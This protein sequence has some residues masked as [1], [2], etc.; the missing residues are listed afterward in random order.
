[1]LACEETWSDGKSHTMLLPVEIVGKRAEALSA[2]EPG[3]VVCI[4]GKLLR[5][6]R[7]EHWET[8]ILAW[9][10]VPISAGAPAPMS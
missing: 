5:R 8:I 9:E 1:M 2:L 7:D 4:D 3:T 10:A 6:K